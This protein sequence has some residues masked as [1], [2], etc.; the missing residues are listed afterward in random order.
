MKI[1]VYKFLI[2][3]IK[4]IIELEENKKKYGICL[5]CNNFEDGGYCHA[6]ELE[7][8]PYK[9]RKKKC[10]YFEKLI[11]DHVPDE[12]EIDD[13]YENLDIFG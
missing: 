2:L 8:F 5:G 12:F 13:Y 7:S 10:K 11:L 9:P 3:E 6:E 4:G 1:S